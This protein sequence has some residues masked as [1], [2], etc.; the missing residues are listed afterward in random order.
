MASV[1]SL[2]ARGATLV[3]MRR[4]REASEILRQAV[5]H[6]PD[7][8]RAW[9][10]LAQSFLGSKQFDDSLS[11]SARASDLA[12]DNDWPHRLRAA[13]LLD[14]GQPRE[15]LTSAKAALRLAPEAT[16][17]FVTLAWAE[18]VMGNTEAALDAA[19]SAV[20]ID[21]ESVI[22]LNELALI[23][24]GKRDLNRAEEVLR[25]ILS[26][27]PNNAQ[28]H[29]NM[30]LISLRQHRV[31]DAVQHSASALSISP[32]MGVPAKNLAILIRWR[33]ALRTLPP[34][35][36]ACA[37]LFALIPDPISY[38][39]AF[40]S[41]ILGITSLIRMTRRLKALSPTTAAL[42]RRQRLTW[43]IATDVRMTRRRWV[44]FT[45]IVV[46]G[47]G[48]L[49]SGI[50]LMSTNP[51]HGVALI[52]ASLWFIVSMTITSFVF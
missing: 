18:R 12:P 2:V 52:A 6:D 1:E 25:R 39:I 24:I 45:F 14:L 3:T 11:A 38:G 35:Y 49:A 19:E 36:F 21:P 50:Y 9:C 40:M 15:A 20:R 22:A 46:V 43:R 5:V 8:V 41:V 7:H 23:L 30:G 17:S 42:L 37:L 47:L 13:A 31:S 33:A 27:D 32:E 48:E 10:L 44:L 29:T 34:Y 26:I 28:A 16:L 51:A 4:Y